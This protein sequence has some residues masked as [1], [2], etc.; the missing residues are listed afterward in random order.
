[1]VTKE[2]MPY[3]SV[4]NLDSANPT[5]PKG[6]DYHPH[7]VD[8][9][10]YDF[11]NWYIS[12]S[13]PNGYKMVVE[14]TRVE[15]RDDVQWGRATDTNHDRS[16][17]WLPAD[18][19]GNRE[20]LLPFNQ[21]TTIFVERAYVL[22]YGK[23]FVL[24]GW[25][26]DDD[27]ELLATPIHLDCDTSDGMNWFDP[28]NPNTSNGIGSTY[29]NT[30][31]GN[32]RIENGQVIYTPTS[33]NW[34]GYDEFYVFGNTW[35]KTVLAQDANQNGNLWNKVTIIP[36]NNIYYEDSF[37]T[38]ESSNVN[39]FE[40]FT[41]SEGWTDILGGKAGENTEIP[42]HLENA[43]YGDVHG[44]TDSLGDDMEFTDDNAHFTNVMGATAEFTFTGTG[45]D[46]YTRTNA[47]SGIVVAFLMQHIENED[48]TKE[49]K[50][51]KSIAIDNLAV[52]GDYYHIPTVSFEK[53]VYGPTMR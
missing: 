43:P 24:S 23:E 29:G 1:M 9:T 5:D 17:L 27:G 51:I 48:G 39:G 12:E 52:S 15:A 34:G 21:P 14:I 45:V 28:S 7:A 20:L 32:V 35:R 31:Y 4:F 26:F 42:E 2:N 53:L 19:N 46:V 44:W 47:K 38:T 49:L 3:L 6:A 37:I 16:G 13:H 22:D 8:I 10:G 33:M 25:Y 36:A 18:E 40:G 41:F 50:E 11:E 30:K